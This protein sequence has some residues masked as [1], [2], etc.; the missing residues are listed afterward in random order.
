LQVITQIVSSHTADSKS[1]NQEVNGT[2]WY[3]PFP[4]WTHNVMLRRKC[5]V[6]FDRRRT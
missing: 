6:V 1:V 3:F 4:A 2:K 5:D